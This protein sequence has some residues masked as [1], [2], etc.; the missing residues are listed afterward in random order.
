MSEEESGGGLHGAR[1]EPFGEI[2][3]RIVAGVC[4]VLT[5][6]RRHYPYRSHD[7]TG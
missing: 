3:N 7:R 4:Q 6:R 1:W 2:W 5:Q